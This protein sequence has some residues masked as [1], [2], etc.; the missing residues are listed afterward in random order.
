VVEHERSKEIRSFASEWS[1][2]LQAI[3]HVSRG[4]VAQSKRIYL[5]DDPENALN[6]TGFRKKHINCKGIAARDGPEVTTKS[7]TLC[8][9]GAFLFTAFR[10]RTALSQDHWTCAEVSPRFL[11]TPVMG[12]ARSVASSESEHLMSD[13]SPEKVRQFLLTKYSEPIKAMGLDPVK[14]PANFDFLLN[15]V[16]DSFGILE[17]ISAIEDEFRIRLDLAALDA[18]QITILDSLSQYV[19]ENS[20]TDASA[21]Q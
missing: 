4:S 16:I 9:R 3:A 5:I 1:R 8:S 18:E 14:V 10:L 17:M 21:D 20:K 12:R 2:D 15:G 7:E 19:A 6:F 13:I 11:A